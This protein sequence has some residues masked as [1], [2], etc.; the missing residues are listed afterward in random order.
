M[1]KSTSTHFRFRLTEIIILHMYIRSRFTQP[2]G[3]NYDLKSAHPRFAPQD[4]I[5]GPWLRKNASHNLPSGELPVPGFHLCRPVE[6]RG[7]G[8]G[9]A[10]EKKNVPH[11]GVRTAEVRPPATCPR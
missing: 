7:A 8:A 4:Q 9:Q 3:E 5:C 2:S 10:E 11:C 6:A 1:T